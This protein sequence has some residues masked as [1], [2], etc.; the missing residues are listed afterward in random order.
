MRASDSKIRGRSSIFRGNGARARSTRWCAAAVAIALVLSLAGGA[1]ADERELR[2]VAQR[3]TAGLVLVVAG[4]ALSVIGLGVYL[5]GAL[6]R[7]LIVDR[8]QLCPPMP[9]CGLPPSGSGTEL[10]VGP[11][12]LAV[13]LAGVA[14]GAPLWALDARPLDG[15]REPTPPRATA[16]FSGNGLSVTF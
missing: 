11:A 1:R 12:F 10:V 4:A 8:A 7:P 15:E 14:T 5:Q 13:G 6:H 16:K 2:H 9:N 3:R